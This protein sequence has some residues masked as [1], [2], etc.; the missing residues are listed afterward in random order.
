MVITIN[1][2]ASFSNTYKVGTYAYYIV[3]DKFRHMKSGAFSSNNYD[4]NTPISE[5]RIKNSTEAEC[6]A[7]C[8][9]LHLLKINSDKIGKVS[10]I[11][12]N[13]DCLSVIKKVHRRKAKEGTIFYDC[14]ILLRELRALNNPKIPESF[15]K[16]NHVTSHVKKRKRTPA[17]HVNEWCDRQARIEMGKLISIMEERTKFLNKLNQKSDGKI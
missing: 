5:R 7:I 15:Y 9:A 12:V 8:N 17:E 14:L 10:K 6:A 4:I 16:L 13:T 11:V 1:S 3:C 2:D